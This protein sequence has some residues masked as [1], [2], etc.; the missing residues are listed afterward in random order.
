WWAGQRLPVVSRRQSRQGFNKVGSP[1]R[2]SGHVGHDARTATGDR[3]CRRSVRRSALRRWGRWRRGGPSVRHL[4]SAPSRFERAVTSTDDLLT[5]QTCSTRFVVVR[6]FG[7][8]KSMGYLT[9]RVEH[10][11]L[12]PDVSGRAPGQ[13]ATV[14]SESEYRQA[15]VSWSP[16]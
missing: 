6:V 3:R 16:S 15:A 9:N 11:C 10:Q 8:F 4:Q 5:A 1:V 13:V 12:P 7:F 14:L 2:G